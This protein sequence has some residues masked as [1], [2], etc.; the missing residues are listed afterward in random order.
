M[1]SHHSWE[2]NWER[3]TSVTLWPFGITSYLPCDGRW[4]PCFDNLYMGPYGTYDKLPA[5]SRYHLLYQ[6]LSY[7]IWMKF[8]GRSWNIYEYVRLQQ[9]DL[10]KAPKDSGVP[11]CLWRNPANQIKLPWVCVGTLDLKQ[12][13]LILLYCSWLWL[14]WSNWHFRAPIPGTYPQ[15]NMP[16]LNILRLR[17][18]LGHCP[19]CKSGT[20]W[21]SNEQ[22]QNM[23]QIRNS[24]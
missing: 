7:W 18:F 6:T 10:V 24:I 2:W 19:V 5:T 3:N 16:T 11:E 15:G 9:R 1:V 17:S 22:R 4:H 8:A 23:W 13:W 12:S 20:Q 14:W 21:I